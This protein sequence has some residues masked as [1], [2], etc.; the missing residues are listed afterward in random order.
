MKK[1]IAI[2]CICF[3]LFNISSALA[4]TNFTAIFTIGKNEYSINGQTYTMDVVPYIKDDRTFLPL[5]Y[6]AYAVGVEPQNIVYDNTSGTITLVKNNKTIKLYINSNILNID[7]NTVEM[8]TK[9]EIINDRV[10]LP[11]YWISKALSININWDP[12]TN[13][14]LV[15]DN[16][17]TSNN[18][19][20]N[21]SSSTYNP[22][23]LENNSITVPSISNDTTVNKVSKDF[24]WQYGNKTYNWQVEIPSELLEWDRKIPE[25]INK[26]YNSNG[27]EQSLQLSYMPDEIKTLVLSCSEFANGNYTPWVSEESNYTYSGNLAKYLLQQA[28]TDRYDSFHIAEFVQSFVESAIPYKITAIPQLPAQTLVDGGDCKDKSILLA[29]ILKNMGYKV[30]LLMFPPLQGQQAGHMA[31]GIAFTD[32]DIPHDL[33]YNLTYYEYDGTKYYFAETTSPGW[34]IGQISDEQLEQNAYVYPVN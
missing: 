15:D 14:V 29:S 27:E 22:Y 10:M 25:E 8:D 2:V 30:A 17:S 26:F 4:E 31:V 6:I 5:R 32:S 12:S 18:S 9:P 7:G 34:L 33:N 13:T 19:S 20:D 16:K 1:I 3:I 23:T 21:K 24:N 28:Q 11:V